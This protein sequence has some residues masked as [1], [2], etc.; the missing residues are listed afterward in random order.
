MPRWAVIK[1]AS[2]NVTK[3]SKTCLPFNWFSARCR[4][5]PDFLGWLVRTCIYEPAEIHICLIGLSSQSPACHKSLLSLCLHALFSCSNNPAELVCIV[6][7]PDSCLVLVYLGWVV[8][9]SVS[10]PAAHTHT[11]LLVAQEG[12]RRLCLDLKRANIERQ[13]VKIV[14]NP[15][16]SPPILNSLYC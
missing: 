1:N 7:R 15:D 16:S 11:L 9:H 2:W 5:S 14:L 12:N 4:R 13:Q 10:G 3:P 8:S 6:G